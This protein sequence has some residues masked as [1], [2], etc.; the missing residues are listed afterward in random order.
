MVKTTVFTKLKSKESLIK[1][2]KSKKIRF[3]IL[4]VKNNIRV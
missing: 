1:L 3:N 2:F 4:K